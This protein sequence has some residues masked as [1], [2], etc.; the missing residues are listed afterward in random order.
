MPEYLSP[1]VYA[2]E[3]DTGSKPIEGASTSTAGMVGVSERGP[4]DVPILV[5]NSGDYARL[6]GG[7][8]DFG[9][10][11]ANAYLPLAVDGFFRNG[12]R[13]LFVSRVASASAGPAAM[14]LFDRGDSLAPQ[15]AL[16]RAASA[17]DGLAATPL[18][19]L[20]AAGL[21]G[22]ERMRVGDGSDAEWP[23]VSSAPAPTAAGAHVALSVPLSDPYPVA[24]TTVRTI[25]E[26]AIATPALTGP[27]KLAAAHG[28]GAITLTVHGASLASDLEKIVPATHMV[29][30]SWSGAPREVVR[31]VAAAR[32]S[33]GL[34]RLTLARPLGIAHPADA[35]LDVFTA[36]TLAS[37]PLTA[38]VMAGD[39]VVFTT[40][41]AAPKVTVEITN[42]GR[43]EIRI[44]G[45]PGRIPL[46]APLGRAL[47]RGSMVEHLELLDTAPPHAA[48]MFDVAA[49]ARQVTVADRAGIPAG[50]I[51]RFGTGS[52]VEYATVTALPGIE[53]GGTATGPGA[54]AL[55]H[56][57]R[58]AAAAGD[59]VVRQ[60]VTITAVAAGQLLLPAGADTTVLLTSQTTD[61]AAPNSVRMTT[62][63]GIPYLAGIDAGAVAPA[64][65]T[66]VTLTAGLLGNHPAGA[67]VV[68]R[69]PMIEVEALD[70]GAW[71]NRLRITVEDE[72]AGLAARA[73][74]TG[75]IGANRLKLSSLAGVE[76]GTILELRSAAGALIGP[77]MKVDAID[78]A[79]GS[80]LLA[81]ALD[82]AQLAALAVP[83]AQIPV[84]SREFRL[85]VLL[86]RRA[87][88]AVPTRSENVEASESFRHL[89]MDPRHSRFIE[90]VIGAID[91]PRRL[92]DRR[93]EGESALVRV[94]DLDRPAVPVVPD[95]REAMLRPGPESL[96]DVLPSG[97]QRAARHPL[98]RGDDGL[99][100]LSAAN[101]IGVDDREPVNR[102]GIFSLKNE[103]D[104]SI[105]AAPGQVAVAVQQA[106][107]THCEEMRY[108]FAV[109]DGPPPRND[110]IADAQALR[111]NYDT[112]YAAMYYPWLTISDPLPAN[113]SAVAEVAVP[114]SGHVVGIYART[115]I[116][117]G[118]HKAPANEVVRGGIAG[119]RR[120][121]NK[122]EHDLL[123]PFPVNINVIRDFRPE[124]RAIRVWGARVLTSDPDY[125]YVPVRRLMLFLEKSIERN[126]NWVVFEPNA[127]PL[128][129]RV[130]Y[131]I[132]AFLET[133]WRNGALEGREVEQAFF[134]ICDRS[135]MTQADIDNGRLICA[136]GVAPV[137]PAEFVIIRIGLKTAVAEE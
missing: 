120:Y 39:G 8:L 21:A 68:E 108:R 29:R 69:G 44:A 128:W 56:G 95:P 54:L 98:L 23:T 125:K 70:V 107:I 76:P 117:R 105:V 132:V 102:R 88:P 25:T 121:L 40:L 42:G 9:E 126:L 30:L 62:P 2:E 129:A 100:G 83:G 91:G 112:K 133:V 1:A 19:V 16:V 118:V 99:A 137:K 87:D 90:N 114:P 94:R 3:V 101:F 63:D 66:T 109:L 73:V 11:G 103:D 96:V 49:G 97:S 131:A 65:V 14:T 28:A 41:A 71:G 110:A 47:P 79:S 130:R 89:S 124:N 67:T 17:G 115:D 6:F 59:Q 74:A 34:F 12:G 123:N 122:A 81:A 93:P 53:S 13:R 5:T 92:W 85:N 20:D 35:G 36:A 72:A 111:Q 127:E 75:A 60:A 58:F 43:S 31:V 64:G 45:E 116:E 106:L 24:A 55:A 18:L 26:T 37:A 27:P 77:A 119:L 46:L 135:T 15:S 52:T 86:M 10:F 4:Q 7:L 104:I 22:G 134:V 48:L 38:P 80:A 82:A 33:P 57:L 32:V 61:F 50:V 78:R 113:L 51:V 84:R 136:V